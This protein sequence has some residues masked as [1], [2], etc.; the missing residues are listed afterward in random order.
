MRGRSTVCRCL[1]Q[2]RKAVRCFWPFASY[3]A[4]RVSL[5]DACFR[6]QLH[7]DPADEYGDNIAKVIAEITR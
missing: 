1:T 4:E 6:R 7:Y 5:F 2:V 3:S